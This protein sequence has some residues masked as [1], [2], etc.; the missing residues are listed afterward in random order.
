MFL[1]I[2][3]FFSLLITVTI[4][5][6]VQL[7]WAT[8]HQTVGRDGTA[9]AKGLEMWTHFKPQVCF[10]ILLICFTINY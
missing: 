9:G 5:L 4:D 1:H 2:Y 7:R 8:K 10:F 3:Y 6:Q